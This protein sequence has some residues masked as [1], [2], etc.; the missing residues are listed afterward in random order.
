MSCEN[1]IC[2]AIDCEPSIKLYKTSCCSCDN[3]SLTEQLLVLFSIPLVVY[4]F[5]SMVQKKS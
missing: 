2:L 5:I 1:N 4:I 3:I